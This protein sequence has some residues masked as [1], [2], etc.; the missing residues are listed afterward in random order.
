[1]TGETPVKSTRGGWRSWAG[2]LFAAIWGVV[3]AAYIPAPEKAFMESASAYA[4]KVFGFGLVFGLVAAVVA[5]LLIMRGQSRGARIATYVV[6]A[7][8]G[9]ICAAIVNR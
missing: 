4:G 2:P 5:H 6:G 7:L 1:M 8:A 3:G 9:G